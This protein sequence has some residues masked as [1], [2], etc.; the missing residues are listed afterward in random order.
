MAMQ[1][2]SQAVQKRSLGLGREMNSKGCTTLQM[3]G[4]AQT[5]LPGKASGAFPKPQ[6]VR[7][8]LWTNISQR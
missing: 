5:L 7:H 3:Q 4:K 8:A 6:L 2:L 1:C